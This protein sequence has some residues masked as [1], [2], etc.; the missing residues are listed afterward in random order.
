MLG[1]SSTFF[2]SLIAHKLVIFE[3]NYISHGK[4]QKSCILILYFYHMVV[5]CTPI[6]FIIC[7]QSQTGYFYCKGGSNCETKMKMKWK[8][9]AFLKNLNQIE[10]KNSVIQRFKMMSRNPHCILRMKV[11]SVDR[12]NYVILLQ[13][14]RII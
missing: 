13:S 10:R 9:D 1:W 6:W 14:N 8:W 2:E 4:R 5:S 11:R 7:R 12:R 3:G